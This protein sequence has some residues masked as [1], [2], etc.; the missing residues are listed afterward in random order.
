MQ[1][2]NERRRQQASKVVQLL[3][4]RSKAAKAMEDRRKMLYPTEV[5][6]A[7]S[8]NLKPQH[9]LKKSLLNFN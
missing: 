3:S 5:V 4:P 7:N 9:M 8:L 2:K 6:S 1:A